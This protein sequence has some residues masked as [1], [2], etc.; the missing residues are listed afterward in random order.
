MGGLLATAVAA[1][2]VIVCCGG[3]EV[4]PAALAFFIALAVYTLWR[5]QRRLF[6]S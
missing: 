3:G 6:G 2:A 1:P 5:R 4:L